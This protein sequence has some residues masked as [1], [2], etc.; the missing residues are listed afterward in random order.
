MP[1]PCP[2]GLFGARDKPFMVQ[3]QVAMDM[4][5]AGKLRKA[6]D[7]YLKARTARLLRRPMALAHGHPDRTSCKLRLRM[8][9]ALA[10]VHSAT[11][12]P[13]IAEPACTEPVGAPT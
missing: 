2:P 11:L 7:L 12:W 10:R 4:E 9:S 3:W 1:E 13:R 6:A 5:N 8:L